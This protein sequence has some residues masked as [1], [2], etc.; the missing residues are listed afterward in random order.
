LLGR[1]EGLLNGILAGAI[2]DDPALILL[3]LLPL[4]VVLEIGYLAFVS[5]GVFRYRLRRQ[6]HRPPG[7]PVFH[8]S[9]SC[10]VTCYSEGR[11]VQ[12][13]ILSLLD[14]D[15]TGRI[16]ILPVIDGAAQNRPTLEAATE[17][18]R[19]AGA[20][21]RRK[22]RVIPK[23]IR[24]GRASSLNAG[25]A[26][27]E[28]EIVMALDG[29]TSFDR[30]MVRRA[31][32]RFRDDSVVA[33]A[34]T[35]RVRNAGH[36]LLTRLQA[37]DYLLFRQF[38]RTGL[39]E[40]NIVN[41]IPGAHGIFRAGFLRRLGGWDTGSAEDVDLTLRIKKYFHG[42]P[43]LRIASDPYVI[44]HTDVP[45]SW[46]EFLRQRLRWEGDP[47]YLYLRKH[48][49][50]LRPSIMGWRNFLFCLWYGLTFQMLLPLVLIL[51]L[52]YLL[53]FA[54]PTLA[55]L[56]LA[57][58]YGLY[59]CIATVLFL[60]H[61]LL[62]SDRPEEDVALAWLLPIYPCFVLMVRVW[63][64]FA[65]CHNLL[66]RSHLDSSMAPWWVLRKGKF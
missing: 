56:V 16:E 20:G 44:S 9:V 32:A 45:T 51:S 11:D 39:G 29:D 25:L 52:L 33:L 50:S 38:V 19:H 41:N 36:N 26:L 2:H 40:F 15:Y 60:L 14:Q 43:R 66:L 59:L 30:D 53:L 62:I 46:W 28:G 65:V 54:E 13:T 63:S 6:L 1:I 17:M 57:L 5:F 8:P 24:G 21:C 12:R 58:A 3:M 31:V 55:L 4:V 61:L 22:L 35:L 34:G 10:I 64:A 27:A 47:A 48:R 7:L 42:N 49:G 23:W 37:L 18:Q